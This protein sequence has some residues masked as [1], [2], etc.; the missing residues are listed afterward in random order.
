VNYTKTNKEVSLDLPGVQNIKAIRQYITTADAEENM[1][2]YPVDTIMKVML[3]PKSIT[4]I[5]IDQ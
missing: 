1:K 2:P 3:K 4:T 5:I